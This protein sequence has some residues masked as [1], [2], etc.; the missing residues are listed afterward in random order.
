MAAVDLCRSAG[1]EIGLIFFDDDVLTGDFFLFFS[2]EATTCPGVGGNGLLLD[3][4]L[5]FKSFDF[6]GPSLI[7][8]DGGC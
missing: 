5:G 4:L 3:A 1:S 6:F 2:T 7:E 8:L